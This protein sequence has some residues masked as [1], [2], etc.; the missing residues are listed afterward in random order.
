MSG[1]KINL[2]FQVVGGVLGI[3][4]FLWNLA[5]YIWTYILSHLQIDISCEKV[6]IGDKQKLKVTAIV[7][8]KG[9][10]AK[11]ID[12]AFLLI[13]PENE[14]FKNSLMQIARQNG[15]KGDGKNITELLQYCIAKGKQL[16]SSI[17]NNSFAMYSLPF[18]YEE[19]FQIGNEKAKYSYL[20]D[21]EDYLEA[22]VYNIRFVTVSRHLLSTY[23]R[24]RSTCDLFIY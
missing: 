11:K 2:V 10:I 6:K 7:E 19:Q 20:I 13:A 15:L 8:N 21:M 3:F 9:V 24:H 22:K 5:G 14:S 16:D 17:I 4:A 23:L 1:E 12:F 18:F